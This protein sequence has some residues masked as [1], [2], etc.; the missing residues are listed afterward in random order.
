MRAG[1]ADELVAFHRVRVLDVSPGAVQ[2]LIG[3]QR[4]WLP[5]AHIKGRLWCRGDQGTLL[6]RR[7]V[8]RDRRLSLSLP[9]VQ[10]LCELL[11]VPRPSPL[12]LVR[13][14]RVTRDH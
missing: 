12:H 7:W 13:S 11:R 10:L 4:V 8:A 3:G 2:C 1:D 14:A 5:R 6:V 9:G